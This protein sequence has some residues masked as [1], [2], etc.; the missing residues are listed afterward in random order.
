MNR[1]LFA[2]SLFL[3]AACSSK[4]IIPDGKN[5]KI[6]RENPKEDCQDLGR[7][8]GSVP[9]IKGTIEQAIE[10]MKMDASRKGAN[11]IRMETTSAI[12]TSVMGTAFFCP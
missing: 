4:P 3:L 10:D 5:V 8:Q 7:V 11:Y 2:I 9:T 1:K 6:S 12:G